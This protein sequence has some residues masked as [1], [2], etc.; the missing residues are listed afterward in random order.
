MSDITV[1]SEWIDD[2]DGDVLKILVVDGVL[3]RAESKNNGLCTVLAFDLLRNYRPM[4]RGDF[5]KQQD[6]EGLNISPAMIRGIHPYSFRSGEWATIVGL[7]MCGKDYPGGRLNYMVMF[8]DG[9]VDYWPVCD[10]SN[11]EIK[12]A[13]EVSK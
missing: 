4:S 3:L 9:K 6:K 5:L 11:H 7:V 10:E 8:D 1:G 2:S 13:S 12:A